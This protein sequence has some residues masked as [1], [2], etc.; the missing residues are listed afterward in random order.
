MRPL[1]LEPLDPELTTEGFAALK[2]GNSYV[3]SLAIASSKGASRKL[4][5]G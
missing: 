5:F 2:K 1:G 4:R 3:I